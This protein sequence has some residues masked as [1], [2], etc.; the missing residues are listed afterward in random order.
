MLNNIEV[1]RVRQRLKKEELADR[2]G[3][4]LKTYYNWVN[5]ETDVPS[6]ALIKMSEM[7]GVDVGYLLV[8][9]TGVKEV[10]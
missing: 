2:L 7:F 8:G 6:S 3:V 9:A 5:E 1:E 10:G 4:S